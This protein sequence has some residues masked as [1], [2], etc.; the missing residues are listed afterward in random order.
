[1]VQPARMFIRVGVQEAKDKAVFGFTSD[2]RDLDARLAQEAIAERLINGRLAADVPVQLTL[3]VDNQAN[4]PPSSSHTI[5]F[6]AL[7]S[8]T[9]TF[10]TRAN[11]QMIWALNHAIYNP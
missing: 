7:A 5:D 9:E 3:T 6:N 1:M 2:T 8:E 10:G 11:V 4:A